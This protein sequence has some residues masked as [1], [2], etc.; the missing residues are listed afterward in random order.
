[1]AIERE[2]WISLEEYHEMERTSEAKLE[3]AN[4]RV[5]AM[6]GGTFNHSQIALNLS[7]VL[8]PHL[9]GKVCRVANSDM[10]VLPL[11]DENPS[12]FPDVT[13]TC[14]PDDYRGDSTA[15]RSPHLI[16]EVLSPGTA[17][18]DRGE[19]LLIYQSC[20]TVEE[21]MMV[22]TQRQQVEVYHREGANKWTLTRYTHEHSVLLASV[23]LTLPVTEIYTDTDVPVLASIFSTD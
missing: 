16:I 23:E 14:T 22:S 21:Y 17:Y 8:T 20:P 2:R 15:I 9:R 1:M 7:A 6:S 13:V 12:Y 3:Y 5:Y 11:G 18:K 4:G 10:K 19:K